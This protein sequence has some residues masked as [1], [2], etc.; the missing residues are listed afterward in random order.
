MRTL[1]LLLSTFSDLAIRVSD[2]HVHMLLSDLFAHAADESVCTCLWIAREKSQRL[3]DVQ[4]VL[5]L[6]QMRAPLQDL[7]VWQRVNH[8]PESRQ[9]TRKDLLAKHL[10]RYQLMHGSSAKLGHLFSCMPTTF[11]LPKDG[12]AFMDAFMRAAHGVEPSV[13]QPK[14]M[15]LWWVLHN[16]YSNA[17]QHVLRKVVRVHTETRGRQYANV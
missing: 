13:T 16:D 7:L 11:S 4:Y 14:G 15:N 1:N 6:L 3:T 10:A 9:L 12:N 8:F 17:Q 2:L 5:K